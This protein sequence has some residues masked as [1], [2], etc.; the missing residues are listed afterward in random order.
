MVSTQPVLIVAVVDGNLD[1]NTGIDKTD[2]GCGNAD[3]VC[4]P[5]VCGTSKSRGNELVLFP[6]RF[7]AR[8]P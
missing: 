3:V 8:V 4:A 5:A 2:D 6:K 7:Q 1:T